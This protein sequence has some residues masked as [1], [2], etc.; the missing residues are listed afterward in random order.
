MERGN[1]LIDKKKITQ[2]VK[3]YAM[4]ILWISDIEIQFT[5]ASCFK[6]KKIDAMFVKEN[7]TI[8]INESWLRDVGLLD[9]TSCILHE[10]R[11]A[12]QCLQIEFYKD[13]I[14][15]EPIDVVQRWEIDF[16][17]YVPSTGEEHSD[18]NCMMQS[19]EIDAVA[20]EVRM[21]KELLDVDVI[22]HESIKDEVEKVIITINEEAL[23]N[24]K[25]C[26]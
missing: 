24:Q 12:Y 3:D 14:Y 19:I 18:M 2:R 5:P 26:S 8:Y 21:M 17:N 22:P 15:Q 11:H 10:V 9:L 16:K 4:S 1:I 23:K 20:F 6:N 7:Y 25:L 13:M